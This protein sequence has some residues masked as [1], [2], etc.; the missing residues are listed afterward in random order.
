MCVCERFV[1]GEEEVRRHEPKAAKK[2]SAKRGWRKKSLES[3]LNV[4]ETIRIAN[5][6]RI[7]CLHEQEKEMYHSGSHSSRGDYYSP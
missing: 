2:R 4:R 3:S 7:E 6:K 1:A 5:K